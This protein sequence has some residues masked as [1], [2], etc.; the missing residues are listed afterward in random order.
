MQ[1]ITGL[2]VRDVLRNPWVWPAGLAV[3]LLGFAFSGQQGA[4]GLV[5]LAATLQLYVPPLLLII[6]IPLLT[7]REVWAF[8]AARSS[9]P[10]RV[11]VAASLGIGFAVFLPLLIGTTLAAFPLALSLRGM[12]LL[13]LALA[14]LV[15][16]W[17]TL[18]ALLATITMDA[19]RALALGLALWA[20]GTL[21]YG[22]AVVALAVN[23]PDRPLFGL[24]SVALLTNPA[25]GIRV[26]LLEALNVPV[27]VGPIALLLRDTLPG[28]SLAWG[29]VSSLAWSA[30]AGTLA[31]ATFTRRDR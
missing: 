27:L 25:E 10:G 9:A 31:A 11:F 21:A 5:S 20:L 23:L 14:L 18:A 28:P 4:V 2:H 24:L 30:L 6:A 8:W 19:T 1:G 15:M 22:P 3:F 12:G 26:G 29:A 13:V 7:R 17:T 16:L